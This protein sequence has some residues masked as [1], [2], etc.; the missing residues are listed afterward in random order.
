[1]QSPVSIAVVKVHCDHMT[2]EV[3]VIHQFFASL[4]EGTQKQR[5]QM[6][7]RRQANPL[8]IQETAE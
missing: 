4:Y 6:G 3:I 5:D 1:M 2:H 7:W 8:V